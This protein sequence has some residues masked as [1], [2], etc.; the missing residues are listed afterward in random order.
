MKVEERK[1]KSDLYVLNKNNPAYEKGKLSYKLLKKLAGKRAKLSSEL[2]RRKNELEKIL[3]H[4][5]SLWN[6]LQ[7]D[8]DEPERVNFVAKKDRLPLYSLEQIALVTSSPLPISF[9]LT[10]SSLYL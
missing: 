3:N 7:I 9:K 10:F 2:E 1:K 5:A 8:E 4:I 6:L